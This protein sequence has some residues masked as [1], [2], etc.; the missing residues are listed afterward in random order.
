MDGEKINI[1]IIGISGYTGL[2]LIRI[3]NKHDKV[4]LK[5]L[6]SRN[7]CNQNISD[8][9]PFLKGVVDKKISN[10]DLEKIASESDLVFLALPHKVSMNFVKDLYGKTKII[11][12]SGDFRI[13][14]KIIY[15]KFYDIEHVAFDYIDDFIYGLIEDKERIELIKNANYIANPGCYAIASQLS[16]LPIKHLLDSLDI[17]AITGSSGSGKA[18]KENTHH[19]IRNHNMSS[20]NICNH[21][22]IPEILQTLNLEEEKFNFIPTSG[23]FARGIFL[24]TIAKLN[25]NIINIKELYKEYYKDCKYIRIVDKVELA[26]VIGS[27]FCDISIKEMNNNSI[28][29]QVAIDNLVKGASGNA[30]HNMNLIFGFNEDDGL[31]NIEVLYP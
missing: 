18:V 6:A 19:P 13:K 4:N 23:P 31:K 1:S 2:E 15:E 5:T 14:N 20:Y 30:I 29:V 12:L 25:Y 8:I 3:L 16:A 26:N 11:D 17:V 9:Y 27:N 7:L 10:I 21:K 28:L 22:H 24:N